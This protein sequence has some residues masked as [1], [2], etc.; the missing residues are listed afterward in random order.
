MQEGLRKSIHAVLAM[1]FAPPHPFCLFVLL[2]PISTLAAQASGT[3]SLGSSLSTNDAN[4]SWPSPSGD[5]A[6]GFYRLPNHDGF[7]LAIWFNKIAEKTVVWSANGDHPV[8]AGSK[9]ELTTDGRLVLVDSQG[10]QAWAAEPINGTV[11][12]A[13]MLDTGNFVLLGKDTAAIAWQSFDYPTDTILPSQTLR[14]GGELSSRLTK[15]DYSKGKFR[16]A[17]QAGGKLAFY[18][19]NVPTGF[20]YSNYWTGDNPSMAAA[21]DSNYWRTTLDFDGVLRKYVY[22]SS[23]GGWSVAS[24]EPANI[25]TAVISDKGSGACGFNSYCKLDDELM[26]TCN[27]PPR[28]SFIDSNNTL[29][30]CKPDFSPQSCNSGGESQSFD[31]VEIV[32]LDWPLADYELYNPMSEQGCRQVC[33]ADCFC[34]VSIFIDGNCWKKKIPLSNG[35]LDASVNRKAFIKV[36]KGT[37]K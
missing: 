10:K 24:F 11:S 7:L 19:V 29:S 28:Y 17:A 5:F 20:R 8:P 14:L 30:D 34:A 35:K 37:D 18:L 15:G 3:I 25:C 1:A 23:R 6:F 21:E 27:C 36:P 26:P 2:L 31:L 12:S 32:N 33:L 13:A 22:S 4:P 16:V 9:A